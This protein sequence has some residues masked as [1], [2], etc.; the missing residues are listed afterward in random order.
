MSLGRLFQ[1]GA[2]VFALSGAI[3]IVADLIPG[4]MYWN[5]VGVLCGILALPTF[6]VVQQTRLGRSGFLA[7][8]F[9]QAGLIGIGGFLYAEA[10]VFA[11]LD[12]AV[13]EQ[14]FEGPT[15]LAIFGS[16]IIY[17][18]G[19]L[20]FV[21]ASLRAKVLPAFGFLLWGVGTAPTIAAIALPSIVM[22]I[23]EMCAGLGVI[24]ISI[25]LYRF[26]DSMTELNR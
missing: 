5:F 9:A 16:V 15:G 21:V 14:L 3:N 10:F 7:F 20:G 18:L 8:V 4:T 12:P 26:A 17:V 11:F 13:T 6:Y 24:W 2:I 22:V 23:A 25:G 1:L 19:V